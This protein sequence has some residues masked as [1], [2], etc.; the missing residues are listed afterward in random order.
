MN[1]S[2]N[3]GGSYFPANGGGASR[4]MRA[5]AE[6][7]FRVIPTLQLCAEFLQGAVSS[8]LEGRLSVTPEAVC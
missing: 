5:E 4:R 1:R 7:S 8:Q 6:L 2:G 3:A